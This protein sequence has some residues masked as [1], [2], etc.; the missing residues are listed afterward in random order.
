[1]TTGFRMYT[2]TAYPTLP[3]ALRGANAMSVMTALRELS[4]SSSPNARPTSFS[5]CPTSP[6]DVPPKVGDWTLSIMIFVIMVAAHCAG[7]CRTT[8]APTRCAAAL[9]C[10]PLL[11]PATDLLPRQP[12]HRPVRCD[13]WLL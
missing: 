12:P 1:M 8:A 11:P 9:Q 7:V 10:A 5:Y 2:S 6:N 3:R 13:F 4:G